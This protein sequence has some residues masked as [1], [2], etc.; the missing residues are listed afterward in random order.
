[1]CLSFFLFWKSS[2]LFSFSRRIHSFLQIFCI[3]LHLFFSLNL[4]I[5]FIPFQVWNNKCAAE[6]RFFRWLSVSVCVSLSVCLCK[7][8]YAVKLTVKKFSVYYL[9]IWCVRVLLYWAIQ[10]T[11]TPIKWKWC[12]E[13]P[14]PICRFLSLEW[15]CHF[16]YSIS[17]TMRTSTVDFATFLALFLVFGFALC[18]HALTNN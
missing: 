12:G 15:F 16:I 18:L 6:P 4:N 9:R 11:Q 10:S 7:W 5:N 14:S 13:T 3:C 8:I 1:M 2:S 17:L